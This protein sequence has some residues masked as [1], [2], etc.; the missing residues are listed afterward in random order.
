MKMTAIEK[1]FVNDPEHARHVAQRAQELL[2]RIDIQPSWRFLDVGCGVGATACEVAKKYG[3]DVTGIDVDPKQIEAARARAAGAGKAGEDTGAPRPIAGED[4]GAPRIDAARTD[5][6]GPRVRF[7]V[8]DATKL[9]FD[10]AE[11]DIVA[12]SM[13]THHVPGWERAFAEMIRVLRPGGYLVYSDLTFPA[14]LAAAGRVIPFVGIPS[15][16]RIE[17]LAAEAGLTKV[18]QSRGHMQ[19]NFVWRRNS[20]GATVSA[21]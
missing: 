13:V 11:F 7:Q 2:E 9:A 14:W 6:V 8:M 15:T 10:D 21:R 20:C 5:A 3:V 1:H 12:T 19:C 18:H 4:T 17:S 16:S